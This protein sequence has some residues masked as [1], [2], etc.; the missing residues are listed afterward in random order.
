M[1]GFDLNAG[2]FNNGGSVIFNNG[3]AGRVT[4]VRIDVAK[5]G[6]EDPDT[7][8]DYK[9]IFTDNNGAQINMG[10]YYFT[11][12][13]EW[14]EERNASLEKMAISRALAVAKSV[15]PDDFVFP[16][17]SNSKEA[18]DALMKITKDHAPN[19]KV[20][21]F[22]T[23]GTKN[24]PKRYL[25]VY[26]NFDFIEKEGTNPSRLR[27][28]INPNKPQY[29]DVMERIVEDNPSSEGTEQQVVSSKPTSMWTS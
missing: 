11:P 23:Y 10:V 17:V 16:K 21:I 25:G 7:S 29:D 5:K 20:N 27:V 9:V 26:K 14:G 28:T 1:S 19:S 18:I 3:Q 6:V 24:A 2:E 13:E 8:P 15:T 12:N 4:G 22:A